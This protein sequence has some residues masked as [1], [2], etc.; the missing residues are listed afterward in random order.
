MS[1]LQKAEQFVTRTNIDALLVTDV[2]DIF[3]L[4]GVHVSCGTLLVRESASIF[5]VDGR[6]MNAV[7]K[8]FGGCKDQ[9][10][11][12]RD[13][14]GAIGI[15]S[16]K[17][18][19]YQLEVLKKKTK[20]SFV[21]LVNPLAIFRIKKDVAELKALQKAADITYKSYQAMLQ[22]LT[23]GITEQDL[24]LEFEIVARRMGASR[25]SFEPIVAF[26]LN[27]AYPHYRSSTKCWDGQEAILIDV[28]AV[29][30]DYCGDLTRV[31]FPHQ[32]SEFYKITRACQQATLERCRPGEPIVDVDKFARSFFKKQGLEKLFVHGLGHGVG[33]SIHEDPS[34]ST[35][36]PKDKIFE[37]NM[38]VTIEP[39]LYDPLIG[40]AR[41][42]DMIVITEN[43]YKNMYPFN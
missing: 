32:E 1:R 41:Y 39:G 2:V 29:V 25:L 9:K 7:S 11:L 30:N 31:Y 4:T 20:C 33:L 3:Y 26:G 42:E 27:A 12:Y 15:D 36:S 28:G 43:G 37:P 5:F 14:K 38:V 22:A 19:C 16:T 34:V 21:K 13:L 18:S 35:K 40:G 24:A 10:E 8:D 23:P 6:Y 17:T